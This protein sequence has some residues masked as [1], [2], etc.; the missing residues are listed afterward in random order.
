MSWILKGR[1][2]GG[3]NNI[4]MQRR[5]RGRRYHCHNARVWPGTAMGT[6]GAEVERDSR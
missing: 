2:G 1:S 3:G 6:V 5:R 4:G